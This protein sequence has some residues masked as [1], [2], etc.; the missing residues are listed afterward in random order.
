VKLSAAGVRGANIDGLMR[1]VKAGRIVHAILLTGPR[2]TGKRTAARMV[3]QA[4][5]CKGQEPPCGV[6]SECKQFLAGSHPDVHIIAT[7]A[8]SISV[9][10]IRA[11]RDELAMRPFEGGRHVA[12]IE[13]ADKMTAQA[14]N[15]LLKTLEEPIGE[16]IFFII[17]DQPG[18]MLPTIVSRCQRLRFSPLG[19][20]ECAQELEKRGI[21]PQR[22]RLLAGA[23]QG[24]V[25]R[26][27]E[28]DGAAGYFER[29]DRVISS[30][31]QLREGRGAVA[32]AAALLEDKK[33]S[34]AD[35]LEIM[36]V[37]AR[38]IM[39]AQNGAEPYTDVS[40]IELDGRRLLMTVME[41][42]QMLAGNVSWMSALEWAYLELVK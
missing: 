16:V 10:D 9:G 32:Q 27:L 34:T 13:Q 38:D 26:A 6:C 3:A 21:E 4:L 24:S 28:I 12:I 1:S 41:L 31:R 33:E 25:G 15:A 8:R 17:T 11:L 18:A 40:G 22:A 14:Q 37:T 30:L 35:I 36:E 42:R 7:D 19:M 20:E 2:G 23:A 29:R 5:L 39:A